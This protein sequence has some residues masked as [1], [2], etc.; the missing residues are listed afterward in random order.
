MY[1]AVVILIIII[2]VV[3]LKSRKHPQATPSTPTYE[4]P[5]EATEDDIGKNYRQ[6]YI[7]TK[8]EYSFYNQLLKV[9]NKRNWIICP[10]V[11]LKSIFEVT[12]KAQYRKYFLTIAQKHVDFLICDNALRPLYAIELTSSHASPDQEK[13][14]LVKESI[15]ANS[16][17]KLI[18]I[19]SNQTY[20]E[21]G[22]EKYF[23]S[24]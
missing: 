3:Y 20:T 12:N 23:Q 17:I 9:A 6:K 13:S 7:L 18:N 16:N 24:V 5:A 1:A 2:L 22:I 14:A 8:N 19:A 4:A 10:K 15:F 21:E 11:D